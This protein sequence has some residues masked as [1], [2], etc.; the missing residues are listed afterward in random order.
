MRPIKLVYVAG[1]YRAKT[2]WEVEQNV[3][4]AE[5]LALYINQMGALAISPHCMARF[6]DR[7]CTDEF[8]IEGFAELL[9]RCDAVIFLI[10]W[11]DS[12]GSKYEHEKAAEWGIPVFYETMIRHLEKWITWQDGFNAAE[13]NPQAPLPEGT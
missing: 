3:R 6:F 11:E 1:P 10:G 5:D 4:H 12:E 7:Q 9:R 2:P 8:W 13:I